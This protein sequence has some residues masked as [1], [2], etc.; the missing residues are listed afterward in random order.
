VIHDV[1]LERLDRVRRAG[2]VQNW[3]DRRTDL[4]DLRWKE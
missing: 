3:K 1:D 2:T 4:Y